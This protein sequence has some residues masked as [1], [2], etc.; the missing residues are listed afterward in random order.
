MRDYRRRRKA[1]ATG[2]LLWTPAG[3]R[4]P[5]GGVELVTLPVGREAALAVRTWAYESLR[6][7]TGLRQG[8]RF[9]LPDFQ[10]DWLADALSVGVLEAGLSMARKNGKTGLI[11]VVNLACLVGPLRVQNWRAIVASMDGG[12]AKELSRQVEEIAI[13]SWGSD[14]ERIVVLNTPAP[15]RIKSATGEVTLLAADKSSGSCGGR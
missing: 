2:G 15:G 5:S 4:G 13:A 9:E 10:V 11:S 14:Q 6:V 12:L 3:E 8:E 1:R 7:P